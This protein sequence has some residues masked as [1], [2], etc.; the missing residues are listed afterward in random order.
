MSPSQAYPLCPLFEVLLAVPRPLTVQQLHHVLLLSPDWRYGE[1]MSSFR[2]LLKRLSPY[3]AVSGVLPP[4]SGRGS[5]EEVSIQHESFATWLRGGGL[6]CCIARGHTLMGAWIMR[7]LAAARYGFSLPCD[8]GGLRITGKLRHVGSV[9]MGG[10][11]GE[12]HVAML[13]SDM[14]GTLCLSAAAES[15]GTGSDEN[16][17]EEVPANEAVYEALF[18]IARCGVPI[19]LCLRPPPIPTLS[20][21]PPLPPSC[22]HTHTHTRMT[23]PYDLTACPCQPKPPHISFFRCESPLT[24]AFFVSRSD[25]Y[26]INCSGVVR[27]LLD[28]FGG[29]GL[30]ADAQG[31]NLRTPLHLAAEAG[32]TLAV[33]LL[34]Q[35]LPAM[36]LA[37]L[38]ARDD[39]GQAA[40][41]L[42][43]S[44]GHGSAVQAL[45]AAD[46]VAS[47]QLLPKGMLSPASTPPNLRALR[48]RGHVH[49]SDVHG[50]D[51]DYEPA[52]VSSKDNNR[53]TALHLAALGG[54]PG[55]VELLLDAGASVAAV[56]IRRRT[57][58]HLAAIAGEVEAVELLMAG[59]SPADVSRTD[60][61]GRTPLHWAARE[62]HIEV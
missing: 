17:D 8:G 34:V 26:N 21:P 32:D 45:L 56:D 38:S 39:A 59:G 30:A 25:A 47:G 14:R 10:A 54:Q 50:G 44:E 18:H 27:L 46:R 31:A 49:A 33:E 35:N 22:P 29:L 61:L 19:L 20:A 23:S 28:F 62:G 7:H 51:T 2:T 16:L 37:S 4:G 9:Q 48:G 52:G 41:H 3:I 57:P 5:R 53:R 24:V 40:L 42:A 43:S 6:A 36:P 55:V 11:E 60:Y 58:L 15:G 12:E 1:D 13:F